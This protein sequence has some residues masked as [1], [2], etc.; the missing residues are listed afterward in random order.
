VMTQA[1]RGAC[2][3]ELLQPGDALMCAEAS[4][5]ALQQV[6]FGGTTDW[7]LLNGIAVQLRVCFNAA[8]RLC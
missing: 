8:P 4:M 6:R 3:L 1:M 2:S 5:Y 7:E